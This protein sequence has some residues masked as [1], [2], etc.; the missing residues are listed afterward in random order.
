MINRVLLVAVAGAGV[1]NGLSLDYVP[2]WRQLLF[3]VLVVAAYLHG[4]HRSARGDWMVLAAAGAVGTVLLVPEVWLGAG[5]LIAVG[6]SVALPWLAGRSRRQQADLVAAGRDRIERLERERALV[7]ERA[8]LRE[9]ARIA[10]DMHDSLGHDLA[11][12]ALRAGAL[13]LARDQSEANRAAAAALRASAVAATDR[14]RRTVGLLREPDGGPP[15]EPADERVAALVGRA[16]AAG[17]R[18]ELR[19]TAGPLPVEVDRAVHRVV[20]EALTNAARHAPGA[21]VVVSVRD[22]GG[23]VPASSNG[24]SGLDGLRE[25]VRLLGGTLAAEPGDGGFEVTAT[26]PYEQ[27]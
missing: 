20:Q 11:L 7:A 24:G 16:R 26:I 12:I 18:V 2:A 23:T 19:D 17:L 8:R 3:V 27:R 5:V 21:A 6:L 9:R 14:L 10:A 4:R 22:S 1:L 25:R 15:T 13:E